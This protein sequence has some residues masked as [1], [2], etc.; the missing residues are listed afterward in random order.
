MFCPENIELLSDILG[1]NT[2]ITQNRKDN[3][4]WFRTDN[5]S[6]Q[7]SLRDTST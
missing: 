2:I 6:Y 5:E 3:V 4:G 1:L 7:L